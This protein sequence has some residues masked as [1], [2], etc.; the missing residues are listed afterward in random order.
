MPFDN[1]NFEMPAFTADAVLRRLTEGRAFLSDPTRWIKGRLFDGA[2][3]EP[4]AACARGALYCGSLAHEAA[5]G[6][7]L[8]LTRHVPRSFGRVDSR[9]LP[10]FNN[11]PDTTHA[12]ILALFDRA[13]AARKA[14]LLQTQS[15]GAVGA[16]SAA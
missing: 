1:E 11:H 12:D 2:Y 13:I 7:D 15:L 6:A 10:D 5:R 3:H 8:C 9:I 4:T 14:E 16:L